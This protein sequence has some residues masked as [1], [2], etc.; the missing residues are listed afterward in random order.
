[1]SFMD[2][3]TDVVD[4]RVEFNIDDG[5]DQDLVSYCNKLCKDKCES[6]FDIEN[7]PDCDCEVSR[8]Y[9]AVVKLAEWEHRGL[10]LDEYCKITIP[11]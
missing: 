7:P 8:L 1:M 10:T 9:Y 11:K 3:Y 2:K 4:G 6:S 5:N